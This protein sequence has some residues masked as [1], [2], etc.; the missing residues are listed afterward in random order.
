MT[1][2]A[3]ASTA[4]LFDIDGTLVDSNYLHVEAW[5]RAFVAV[6]HPVDV[7]RIHRAIGMDSAD[8][9]AQ[10]LGDDA[11]RL[12]DQAKEHHDRVYSSTTGRL[13]VIQGARE[14][15]AELSSRGARVVLATSAP[16]HELD[17]LLDLL[18]V[19]PSVD[20]VTSSEDVETAK[21]APD[22]I[23]VALQR[24]GVPAERAVMVG[25]AVWDVV[26]AQRAGV[27]C[28][29]LLSGGYGRE[30]LLAAGAVVVYDDAAD[31]LSQLDGS[32]ISPRLAR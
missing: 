11:D 16:Q 31:L 26:A 18:D 15:L 20:A 3:P 23:E 22:I 9:L 4:V 8:L 10:A 17:V 14:L 12:G 30:E 28:I 29:G 19:A 7:W 5:D 21:P 24:A 2:D 1:T 13:R 25:D 6:G 32:P 27:A